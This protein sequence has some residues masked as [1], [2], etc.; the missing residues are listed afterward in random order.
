MNIKLNKKKISIYVISA[1]FLVLVLGVF[2]VGNDFF[3]LTQELLKVPITMQGNKNIAQNTQIFESGMLSH[4]KSLVLQYNLH[5]IC[6]LGG[7]ASALTLKAED[8]RTYSVSLADYGENCAFGEQNINIPLKD[9][10]IDQ[11]LENMRSLTEQFWYPTTFTIEIKDITLNNQLADVLYYSNKNIYAV[12]RLSSK[13]NSFEISRSILASP[14]SG[15]LTPTSTSGVISEQITSGYRA[16]YWNISREY[17]NPKIPS[18]TPNLT[19]NDIAINFDWNL[20][21]PDPAINVDHFIARWQKTTNFDAGTYRFTVTADDGVRVY[22]DNFLIINKWKNQPQTT[23]KSNK[24]MTSGAHSIRVEYYENI[25]AAAMKFDFQKISIS[26]PSKIETP[27][28]LPGVGVGP[29]ATPTLTPTI[30]PLPSPTPLLS[31]APTPTGIQPT[32]SYLG[33]YWNTPNEPESYN[34]RIPTTAPNLKRNDVIINFPWNFDSPAP[35]INI[36]HF[37][38]RWQKNVIFDAGIYRFS[39]VVDD[40]IRVYIDNNL[41]IDEWRDQ[42]GAKFT[43]DRVVTSG[44]HAIKIEYFEDGGGAGIEFNFQKILP[45]SP[46]VTVAPTPTPISTII[47]TP[48]G[49]PIVTPSATATP[50]PTLAPTPPPSGG[51]GSTAWSIKSVSSMKETKDKICNQ[52]SIS[53]INSWIDKAVQ[54]G[55]NYIAVETPYDNPACGSSVAYTKAWVDAIHARG[56]Y[57]W[58]RHMPL[59]FEGIYDVTKNSSINYL[60]LIADYIKTNPTFFKAGDIFSPIPEPQNGGISGITYCPQNI[61]IFGSA[62]IFNKWLRDAMTTSESAFGSIGL[63]GKMKIGYFGF[64][65]F[66]AWGDNNPDWHGILEDSTVQAM[67]NITIDHYP[68]IVGDTMENDL[69]EIQTKYPNMPIIIGEWGT[70]TGGDITAQV[71]KSMQA[72]IR[73]NVI[74][75]NYWHMGMGG[76]EKLINDDFTNRANF[77][78]VKSFFLR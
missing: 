65:G 57:V 60:P 35:V 61:C 28:P 24:V 45:S 68:E 49:S 70:I 51:S 12:T 72:A 18:S 36:D 59:A 46:I 34:P 69:N 40:G 2:I 10:L 77:D 8:E 66:V 25:G 20:G 9:F 47:S 63:G 50:I 27:T 5:G 76:N 32:T 54:L 30:N 16:E 53:F 26:I 14:L 31:I 38:V 41:I 29:T 44:V 56:L 33:E 3:G 78:A 13:S 55:A 58:H 75:F 23:F 52:D 15:G 7:P 39:A 62:S 17:S 22:V 11:P 21:S 74:G 48:A 6:L 71:Y 42:G 67:G 43:A 73:P 1:L 4:K 19:R 64:D 37:V